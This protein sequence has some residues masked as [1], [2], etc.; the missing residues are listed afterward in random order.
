MV[1][2]DITINIF[3]VVH[4][5]REHYRTQHGVD[6][7]GITVKSW[8]RPIFSVRADDLVITS[9][10]EFAHRLNAGHSD[11]P[12]PVTD[13]RGRPDADAFESIKE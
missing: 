2:A 12:N 9:G 4:L 8:N 7:E 5:L 1:K 6:V 11:E 10:E 3:D 13:R